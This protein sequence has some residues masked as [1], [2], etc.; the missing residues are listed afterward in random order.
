MHKMSN[1]L[2]IELKLVSLTAMQGPGNPHAMILKEV[3]G[4]RRLPIIIGPTEAQSILTYVSQTPILRPVTHDLTVGIL[5][6]FDVEVTEVLIYQVKGGVFY[7][8]INMRREGEVKHV[9]SRPSDAIAIAL[10]C[11]AP[12]Y[13]YEDILENERIRS[14]DEINSDKPSKRALELRLERAVKDEDYELAAVLR[15]QLNQT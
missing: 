10:R 13:V 7:T 11:R 2:K 12:I 1:R 8:F 4:D 14:K 3:G 9:D 6:I 5:Q 15:D